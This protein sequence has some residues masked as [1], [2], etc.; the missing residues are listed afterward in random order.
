MHKVWKILQQER[1]I[2][3]GLN[4]I[5]QE[6]LS[7]C[8]SVGTYTYTL[9]DELQWLAAVGIWEAA[10]GD[11]HVS[12]RGNNGRRD[13]CH[14]RLVQITSQSP[15]LTTPI[16]LPRLPKLTQPAGRMNATSSPIHYESKRLIKF[17]RAIS[18]LPWGKGI[19]G[20]WNPVGTSS[21]SADYGRNN[22]RKQ[23]ER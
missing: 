14:P 19:L 17:M 21:E 10:L 23:R 7:V 12:Q 20:T 13:P 18:R 8:L 11:V 6:R 22:E 3:S 16:T 1:V 15:P 2:P 4:S 9:P 5:H